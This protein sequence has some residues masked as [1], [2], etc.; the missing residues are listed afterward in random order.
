MARISDPF[1]DT[2]D[3]HTRLLGVIGDPIHH[4]LSPVMH[5]LACAQ[6]GLNIRYLPFHLAQKELEVGVQGLRALGV[7]GFNAT[8]PHKEA[9]VPLMDELDPMARMIGAVNTV[10][11]L[12]DG[13]LKGFNTDAYGFMTA[14]RERFDNPLD[15]LEIVVLGAGGATRAVLAGLLEAGAKRI[16][17]VNRTYA[18]A[19]ALAEQFT[20]DYPN[21]LI[22]PQEWSAVNSF[23]HGCQ[24]LIN[25]T[26]LG[27]EGTASHT[28][29]LA[30]LPE[31][32]LVYDIV[33]PMTPLLMAAKVRGLMVENGLGM[34]IHQGAKAFEIWTGQKMDVEAVRI[35]VQK[36]IH[37]REE[38]P[39]EPLANE[40]LGVQKMR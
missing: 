19:V 13:R 8:I 35:Y 23:L 15:S 26:S 14:L 33:Y 37:D 7:M 38:S 27:L 11:I 24:L 1:K 17:L 39:Q 12:P 3:G 25:T 4:S 2:I 10:T 32:A 16:V 30:R 20:T 21:A 31:T 28:L 18:R 9:L 6:L 22:S 29:E 34:L 5:N 36:I 40:L